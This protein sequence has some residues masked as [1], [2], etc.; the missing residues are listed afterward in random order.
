LGARPRA[1]NPTDRYLRR[2]DGRQRHMGQVAGM[3]GF[4]MAHFAAAAG[5]ALAIP[6][7][8]RWKRQA[9]IGIDITP[10]MDWRK[11]IAA[12]K[13]ENDQGPV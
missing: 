13:V 11:P 6:M 3:A 4:P 10:S 1:H 9:A 8:L 7:T 5:T 12:Q 2:D